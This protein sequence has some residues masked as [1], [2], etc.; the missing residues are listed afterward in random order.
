MCPCG[1]GK[2][3]PIDPHFIY[4]LQSLRDKLNTP[5]YV[6]NGLR[7]LN[8]N[9]KIGGYFNSAHLFG[10]G[11]DIRVPGMNIIKLAKEAKSVGFSRV[12]LYPYSN[13]VHIDVMKAMPSSAWVRSKN[14]N[15]YYFKDLETAIN[16]MGEK[17]E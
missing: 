16:F 3:R 14:G 9:K 17:Y 12:G 6:T 13:F 11:A 7:C 4:L 2:T 1:C 8:Y 10:R 5:I 15:Y